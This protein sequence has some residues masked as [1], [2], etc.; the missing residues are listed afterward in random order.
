MVK[1]VKEVREGG[2]GGEVS[3]RF[4]LLSTYQNSDL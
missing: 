3:E 4:R 2:E 1:E